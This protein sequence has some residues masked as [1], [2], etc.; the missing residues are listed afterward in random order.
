MRDCS[1]ST[2][3]TYLRVLFQLFVEYL[4][5]VGYLSRAESCVGLGVEPVGHQEAPGH[6]RG[7]SGQLEG[8]LVDLLEAHLLLALET[9]QI[10][11]SE[12]LWWYLSDGQILEPIGQSCAGLEVEP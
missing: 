4:F 3:V 9:Q 12:Y 2:V 6:A 11:D 8:H 10:D 7:G 5:G 1:W